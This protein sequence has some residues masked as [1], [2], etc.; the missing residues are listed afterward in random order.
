MIEVLDT[1]NVPKEDGRANVNNDVMDTF[2]FSGAS[3]D[4]RITCRYKEISYLLMYSWFNI[5]SVALD[6]PSMAQVPHRTSIYMG[7]ITSS[8]VDGKDLLLL[9][10]SKVTLVMKAQQSLLA[11]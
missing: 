8:M 1:W 6:D 5:K 10:N 9:T 3:D 7:I 4:G 2:L 11:L